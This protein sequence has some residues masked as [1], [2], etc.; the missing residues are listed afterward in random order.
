[1]IGNKTARLDIVAS[2]NGIPQLGIEGK[3]GNGGLVRNQPDVFGA[4]EDGSA[5]PFGGNAE[6]AGFTRDVPIGRPMPFEILRGY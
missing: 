1:M 3:T 5:I 4:F 6:A 2:L